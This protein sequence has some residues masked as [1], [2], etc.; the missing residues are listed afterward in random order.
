MSNKKQ[1]EL[2]ISKE[3]CAKFKK[4]LNSAF[5]DF[6]NSVKIASEKILISLN[7]LVESEIH[8]NHLLGIKQPGKRLIDLAKLREKRINTQKIDKL[9]NF[10]RTRKN[11]Q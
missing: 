2:N 3:N 4:L 8:A 11:A 1:P 7:K 5:N 6:T 10:Q 9:F